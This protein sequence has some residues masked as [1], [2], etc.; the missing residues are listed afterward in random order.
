MTEVE[1]FPDAE[2][3]AQAAAE[4]I[5]AALVRAIRE[6]GAAVF[7]ATGGRSPG[8]VY[9]RLA[10]A[11][12][13]WSRVAVVLSDERWVDPASPDSNQRLLAERL[14]RGRAGSAGFTPLKTDAPDA[15]A[16]ALAVEAPVAGLAPFAATLLGMGEDGHIASLFPGNPALAQGLDPAGD[17]FVVHAPAGDPAPV[18]D[19][20]SLTLRALLASDLIVVLTAG[21]AKRRMIERGADRPI[22]T[23]L[24]QARA[25]VRLIWSPQ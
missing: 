9:D 19:R 21:E 24:Q 23:L 7:V 11:D 22:H 14:F 13:D 4:A 3:A 25:P 2:A 15:A 20:V 10:E 1:A 8:R 5:A 16:G 18:Q 6:R 17:R 12:L